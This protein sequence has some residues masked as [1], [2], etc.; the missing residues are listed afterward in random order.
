MGPAAGLLWVP[1]ADVLRTGSLEFS[2]MGF[3]HNDIDLAE[4]PLDLGLRVSPWSGWEFDGQGTWDLWSNPSISSF[5][6][7]FSVKNHLPTFTPG[8]RL[9]W[10]GGLTAASWLEGPMGIPPTDLL[11]TF[12]GLRL[13]LAAS[14][15]WGPWTLLVSP[16]LDGSF[17]SPSTAY[18]D[19]PP[20]PA[21]RAWGYGRFG[22]DFN[23]GP[24]SL[25]LSGVVRTETF[26]QGFGLLG[27]SNFGLE[28]RLPLS[29]LPWTLSWYL[30]VAA[31]SSG[32][33]AWYSGFGL[34]FVA[35]AW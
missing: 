33:Y 6:F 16:E 5:Y 15:T 12:P 23:P 19:S 17:W 10:I 30:T 27:P 28:A 2:A 22:L 14:W 18:Y 11:T 24:F 26:D 3:G 1:T 7:T 34:S 8:F 9:A 29:N 31:Y 21:V 20:A 13:A 25:G 32:D 35:S 4:G